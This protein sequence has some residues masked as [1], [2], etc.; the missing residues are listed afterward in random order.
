M[1]PLQPPGSR[2]LRD[3]WDVRIKPSTKGEVVIVGVPWDWSTSGRPGARFAP[4]KLR[5]WIYRFTGHAPSSI[6][7]KY[8][9]ADLGDVRVAPGDIHVTSR[10][11]V[12]AARIAYTQ[13]RVAVFL[14]GDHSITRW[15]VE[16]IVEG[17]LG[18]LVLD[19]HYDMRSV[20]EGLT[21][22][23]WLWDLW[24]AH[25]GKVKAATIGVSDYSNPEYLAIRAREAGFRI[26]PRLKI[27]ENPQE[28]LEAVDWLAE[29]GLENFYISVDAD[30]LDISNAPGV[31][32]PTP[33]GM[34]PWE[35]LRI[36]DYAARKLKP[37][38]V[39]VVEI[40]PQL[41]VADITVAT[42]AKLLMYTIHSTLS[43]YTNS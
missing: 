37:R 4:S 42:L 10:R 1:N 30:H 25:K 41:D 26:T 40:T 15:T 28:A 11:I 38:G 22:G 17:G 6:D 9:I 24:T 13:G 32:S 14:G 35:S 43:S 2:L 19:A 34:T 33:L 12:E 7:F 36:L 21:S 3:P 29:Q 31:N 23:S 8:G 18:I 20:E 16:P 39:D 5:E 27:L